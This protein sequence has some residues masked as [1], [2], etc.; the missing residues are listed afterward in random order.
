MTNPDEKPRKR[1]TPKPK[2]AET[3]R[4]APDL[5]RLIGSLVDWHLTK[6]N[7]DPREEYFEILLHEDGPEGGCMG[8]FVMGDFEESM[9]QLKQQ[10]EERS[11]GIF[12]YAF[13]FGGQWLGPDGM[14]HDGAVVT[15]ETRELT[16]R[17]MGLEI[18]RNA[19]GRLDV[20]SQPV[21]LGP[22]SWSLF[23]RAK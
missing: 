5:N 4:K 7:G 3:P 14:R 21:N 13:S 10:L 12:M 22:A 16:P 11:A 17:L 9:K 6:L 2:E 1:K 15:F 8:K 20:C 19:E 18:K 23:H